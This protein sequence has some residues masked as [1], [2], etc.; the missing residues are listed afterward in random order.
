MKRRG[1]NS[2]WVPHVRTSV[3]GISKTGRSPFKALTTFPQSKIRVPHISLVFGE[4]WD[5]TALSPKIY[6]AKCAYPTVSVKAEDGAP[7]NPGD[8]S[9][10]KVCGSGG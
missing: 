6:P 7:G 3:R 8:R 9:S 2:L 1:T 5:S 4:M 10:R